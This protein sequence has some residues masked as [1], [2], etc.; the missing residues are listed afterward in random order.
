MNEDFYRT[1]G[2]AP[3]ATGA[4]IERAYR[5]LA[6]THHPDLLR[7][8]TTEERRAAE[9]RLKAINRAHHSLGDDERRRAYD[10][11]RRA[12]NAASRSQVAP[13]RPASVGV[14]RRPRAGAAHPV[15]VR[16]THRGGGG[17]IDIE[18]ETAPPVI[19]RP[20]TDLFTVGRLLRYALLIV[21]FALLLGILWHPQ[22]APSP[23]PPPT[24]PATVR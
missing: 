17:P 5:R 8:A 7:Q 4:E 19:A 24:A 14:T 23:A 10:R 20:V 22:V 15:A 18:W 9:E 16:S 11:Q 3:T 21:L 2:V 1:L 12:L 13:A 6:R